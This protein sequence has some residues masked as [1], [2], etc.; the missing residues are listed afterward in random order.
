MTSQPFNV[1]NPAD[2]PGH[3]GQITWNQVANAID[4]S[5]FF[6]KKCTH[7][8]DPSI[9][10]LACSNPANE[11][12]SGNAVHSSFMGTGEV[13]GT[14]NLC[15]TFVTINFGF[16]RPD[17]TIEIV[18]CLTETSKNLSLS[19]F[20]HQLIESASIYHPRKLYERLDSPEIST[21]YELGAALTHRA[22]TQ[23]EIKRYR[24]K[25]TFLELPYT[26]VCCTLD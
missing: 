21:R 1:A 19:A 12:F 15:A 3:Q 18:S 7:P 10:I 14:G 4:V 25:E 6:A 5:F 2:L 13:C 23:E 9:Y 11:F 26:P 8:P 17:M 16:L 20:S 24:S 22:L